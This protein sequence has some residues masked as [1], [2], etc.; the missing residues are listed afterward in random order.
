M[1]IVAFTGALRSPGRVGVLAMLAFASLG[2]S[3]CASS[4]QL[5]VQTISKTSRQ[6]PTTP[7]VS[8]LYSKPDRAYK[9]IAI[10]KA[11]AQ[12]GV[13]GAQ[14]IGALSSK[15]RQIGANALIVRDESTQGSAQ[16]HFSP[17]GGNYKLSQGGGTPVFSAQAIR[18]LHQ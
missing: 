12:P 15:A 2:L 7:Y 3:G 18:W 11:H 5:P 8:V 14:I 4:G 6:Y 1:R 13:S 10:L 17:S 9:V 16:L